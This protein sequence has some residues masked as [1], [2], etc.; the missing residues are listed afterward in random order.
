MTIVLMIKP[1]SV[2]MTFKF[3]LSYA[4]G[5]NHNI[6]NLICMPTCYIHNS[7]DIINF[8][9]KLNFFGTKLLNMHIMS[10]GGKI[11]LTRWASPVHPELGLGWAIKLLA[12]KKSGQI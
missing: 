4:V 10:R 9:K 2:I 7:S 11:G 8:F 6:E 3:F 5:T 12:Q 1:S